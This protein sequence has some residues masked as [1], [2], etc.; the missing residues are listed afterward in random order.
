[1]NTR[2]LPSLSLVDFLKLDQIIRIYSNTG[3]GF[4]N[5]AA[6]ANLLR[7]IS[8][9]GFKGTFEFIYPEAVREKIQYLFNLPP[10]IPD[11]Y[12][13]D[14]ILF[15]SLEAHL[16]RYIN[17]TLPRVMLAMTGAWDDDFVPRS[18]KSTL[19]TP[20]MFH[21]MKQF[22]LE[23][24]AEQERLNFNYANLMNAEVF[25]RFSAWQV[26]EKHKHFRNTVFQ[27]RD[28]IDTISQPNSGNKFLIVPTNTIA[29]AQQ[30]LDSANGDNLLKERP[31]LPALIS[32]YQN[33][34]IKIMSCYGYTLTNFHSPNNLIEMMAGAR[35]AQL[36]SENVDPIIIV[37]FG[38]LDPL[39]LMEIYSTLNFAPSLSARR[40][41]EN[42]HLS[43]VVTINSLYES[44]TINN[45]QQIKRGEILLI[46][47]GNLPQEVFNSL[48]THTGP[49]ILLQ[50]REGQSTFVSLLPTGRPHLRC[51]GTWE[52]GIEDIEDHRLQKHFSDVS[53]VCGEK[54]EA[55]DIVDV[56]SVI[57][58]YILDAQNP[59]SNLSLY[60]NELSLKSQNRNNDRILYGLTGGVGLFSERNAFMQPTV[61]PHCRTSSSEIEFFPNATLLLISMVNITLLIV[62]L[63]LI[64]KKQNK[65]KSTKSYVEKFHFL[66]KNV[67]QK[68][69][70]LADSALNL[71]LI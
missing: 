2:N 47:T 49:N 56:P 71:S 68:A 14:G 3:A 41:L 44:S 35:Y 42:L 39:A 64:G 62:G 32:A 22:D 19:L 21:S 70:N 60:F 37:Y 65:N 4:G 66:T 8:N 30:F 13:G 69:A 57:G 16:T 36:R 1:M 29:G 11:V 5:Q 67:Q 15:Y 43:S 28:R 54:D 33:T 50:V 17:C 10:N 53:L 51:G 48:Y 55:W 40:E 7:R 45:I 6:N 23:K 61:L 52:L 58:E 31:A 12:Q 24:Y 63:W 38:D 34:T 9:M 59:R 26:N 46:T 20:E 18:D 25:I 27:L